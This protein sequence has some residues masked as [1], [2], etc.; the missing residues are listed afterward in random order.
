M[1]NNSVTLV[2]TDV[3]IAHLRGVPA[4]KDWLKAARA[5]GGLA[6]SAITVTEITGGMRTGEQSDVWGLLSI[7][8]VEPVTDSVARRAGEFRRT[9]RAGHS[10]IG[11]TDYLIAA[12]SDLIKAELATLNVKHFP[13]FKGLRPPFAV[14]RS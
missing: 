1:A 13:M 10:G 6:I 3:L 11:T 2:D 9:Y 14:A 7:F 5:S 8:K 12:T 4:A